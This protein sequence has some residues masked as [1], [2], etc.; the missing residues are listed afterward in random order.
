MKYPKH[1]QAVGLSRKPQVA[2]TFVAMRLDNQ[3]SNGNAGGI[4]FQKLLRIGLGFSE[5]RTRSATLAINL[6][7]P[8]YHWNCPSESPECAS[9]GLC[10]SQPFP[11]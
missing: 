7:T 11:L 8:I 6:I 5:F 9:K 10:E 4:R 3:E 2:T 1:Q